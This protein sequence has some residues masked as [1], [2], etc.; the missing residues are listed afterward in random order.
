MKKILALGLLSLSAIY[1][2]QSEE[3]N[4]VSHHDKKATDEKNVDQ[5]SQDA[6]A[7]CSHLSMREE[8][9]A[10]QLSPMHQAIFCRHFSVSQRLEAISLAHS[11]SSEGKKALTPDEA[12]EAVMQH[13]RQD[14]KSESKKD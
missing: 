4:K 13:A 7:D 6:M 5:K 2:G 12:V 14:H 3:L 10:K 8:E 9:F 11:G 1:A